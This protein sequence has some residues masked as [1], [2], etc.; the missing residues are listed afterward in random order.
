VATQSLVQSGA[1]APTGSLSDPSG[2]TAAFWFYLHFIRSTSRSHRQ[3][4]G[5]TSIARIEASRSSGVDAGQMTRP[6]LEL[7]DIIR[8]AGQRLIDRHPA[9]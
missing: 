9:C 1:A 7:A 4:S 8:A 3:P 6:L 2:V 5:F